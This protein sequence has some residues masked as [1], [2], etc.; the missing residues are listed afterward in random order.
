MPSLRLPTSTTVRVAASG[1][2]AA[3]A[4]AAGVQFADAGGGDAVT[5]TPI[6][7]LVVL[8]QEN[9]S[10]DH[11]FG[12][13]P[14]AVNGP[15]EIPF[16]AA[17]GTPA[18]NGLTNTL[19]TANPNGANPKR[20]APADVVPTIGCSNSH[21]YSA[22]QKAYHGGLMDQFRQNTQGGGCGA[23]GVLNY[24]DGNTVTGLWNYAQHYAM[25]DNFFG[26]GFGPST[27]GAIELVSGN[28]STAVDETGAPLAQPGNVSNGT[29]FS[30]ANPYP[31]FDGCTAASNFY[32]LGTAT[33]AAAEGP[34]NTSKNIGNLLHKHDVSWGW[35]QGGFTP[36]KRDAP[37]PQYPVAGKP[38]CGSAHTNAAG[39]SVGDYD[40]HH[41]P[42]AY[43][44]STANPE[45]LPPTA[46]IGED[47]QANHQ[48]DT[49][50]FD[51]AV[52]AG[53]LPAVSFV[54]AGH[55]QDGH[56]GYSDPI[57]EQRFLVEKIN[58][59]QAS[60]DWDSTAIIIAWDDSDGW[61]DHQAPTIV[62]SSSVPGLDAYTADGQCGTPGPGVTPASGRCGFGP[63]L[64]FLVISPYS[65][66]NY[67]KHSQIDQTSILKFIEYNWLGDE[68]IGNG[69]TDDAAGPIDTMF[70]FTPGAARRGK[71]V[72]DPATGAVPGT[73][74]LPIPPATVPGPGTSTP[75]ATVPSTGVTPPPTVKTTNLGK[76]TLK[77]KRS[78]SKK[79][80]VSF[81]ATAKPSLKTAI[82]VRLLKGKTLIATGTAD[83][84]GKALKVTLKAKKAIKRGKYTLQV[85]MTSAGQNPALQTKSLKL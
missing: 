82:R 77:A 38:T 61:Y 39:A 28:T 83:Y 9:T 30:N 2:I 8:F 71:L 15:G 11:D 14:N 5:K 16:T 76:V 13:Y 19:L 73:A 21:E 40:A 42:F 74:R 64:P 12:T 34:G 17:P 67:V 55:Y 69:S 43:Y 57:D 85:T 52:Q 59:I 20:I 27:I 49:T 7:H 78:G 54:K 18:V 56:P 45:H 58:E 24:V 60:P 29:I 66:E 48:Y 25:A 44:K 84:K 10:F 51:A 72:L 70:D 37:S 22:E 32:A 1:L 46:A 3:A 26:T 35:F 63:R 65:K 79:L 31:S 41:N 33:G 50:D 6:K 80:V 62:R 23:S 36:S 81:A 75:P 47:D 68:R 53:N 4:I